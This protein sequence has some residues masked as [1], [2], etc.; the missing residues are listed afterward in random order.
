MDA[1]DNQAE[2][3]KLARSQSERAITAISYCM[4]GGLVGVLIYA[5]HTGPASGLSVFSNGFLIAGACALCGAL[6]GF[7]F[8]IPRTLQQE[9]S[10][11][12]NTDQ[13]N[14]N[15]NRGK[16]STLYE[17]NT[18]LEQISD[19][20]TKILVG[21]GLTQITALPHALDR[22]ALFT[23]PG[24]GGS[25]SSGILSVLMLF[26]FSICG[27]LISYLWTRLYLAGE[28]Y[29]ANLE[30]FGDKI[31][32]V[33]NKVSE[34]ERQAQ[35]DAKAL[36]LVQRQLSPGSSDISQEELNAAII[37]ASKNIK[38]QIFFQAEYLRRLNWEHIRSKPDMEKT[39]PVFRAL[40]QSD[41]DNIYHMNHGQLG[42]ALKDKLKPDWK[43]AEDELTRAIELRTSE[44]RKS[45]L[46]Y[47]MCRAVCSIKLDSKYPGEKSDPEIKKK[48]FQDIR[49]ARESVYVGKLVDKEPDI[50]KWLEINK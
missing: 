36:L 20:L 29:R 42:F 39:I 3:T 18:N 21:V 13:D 46:I 43:E 15:N 45:W 30:A 23:A 27:F 47:E 34:L 41:K 35:I 49:A 17:A 9:R 19:W 8:G 5:F 31:D 10:K 11:I 44:D 28:L 2:K 6:L 7:L 50:Q 4:L 14:E 25:A 37:P 12:N 32:K 1:I 26:F 38:A 22:F 16:E 40:I 33:F 24:L 48:I